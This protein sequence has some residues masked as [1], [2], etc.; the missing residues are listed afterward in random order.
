MNENRKQAAFEL[1]IMGDDKPKGW[2]ELEKRISL[3]HSCR[4]RRGKEF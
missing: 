4:G 2:N 3:R 1:D